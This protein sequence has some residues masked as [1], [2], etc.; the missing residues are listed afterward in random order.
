MDDTHNKRK[1]PLPLTLVADV[2]DLFLAIAFIFLALWFVLKLAADRLR[3]QGPPRSR[4]PRPLLRPDARPGPLEHRLPKGAP[5]PRDEV[6]EFLRRAQLRRQEATGS[7]R[8][9]VRQ[10]PAP[11]LAA[12]RDKPAPLKTPPVP[13]PLKQAAKPAPAR[14][15]KPA[16]A[17]KSPAAA[18]RLEQRSLGDRLAARTASDVSRRSLASR[19]P[20][21]YEHQLG[22]LDAAV[23]VT[24]EQGEGSPA[25]TPLVSAAPLDILYLLQTGD[26]LQQV[27]ILNEI[28]RRPSE[29]WE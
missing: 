13:P 1:R 18:E 20:D 10:P 27:I 25:K 12:R 7:K 8:P 21:A 23:P 2:Q 19:L 26:Q 17:G 29:R 16:P 28:L 24:A 9:D 6:A 22:T 3:A 11:R 5:D 14:A 4:P 15:D